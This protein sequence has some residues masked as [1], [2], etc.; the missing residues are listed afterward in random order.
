IAL[1]FAQKLPTESDTVIT[2]RLRQ[3]S[4]LRRATVGRFRL[5]LSAAE[6]SWPDHAAQSDKPLRGLPANGLE[7]LRTAADQRT[8]AQKETLEEYFKWPQPE[9][10]P[11][12]VRV[13]RLEAERDRLEAEIPRVVVT[14][15]TTPREARVLPRGNWM[16]DSGEVVSPAIPAVFGPLDT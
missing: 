12:V 13:A 6:Y 16:D 8:G 10:E 2:V 11:L 5:A 15:A 14:E 9:W 7:A 3:G 4:N 1:R